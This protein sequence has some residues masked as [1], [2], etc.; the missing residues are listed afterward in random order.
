MFWLD[1]ASYL[2]Q[3]SQRATPLQVL[4]NLRS[5]LKVISPTSEAPQLLARR[6]IS[7]TKVEVRLEPI[8]HDKRH[9]PSHRLKKMRGAR[10]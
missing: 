7:Q 10:P 2:R 9:L 8:K 6:S 4:L 1:I 5:T 3:S